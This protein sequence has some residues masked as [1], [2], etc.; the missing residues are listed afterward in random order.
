MLL[1]DDGCKVQTA[2]CVSHQREEET[3]PAIWTVQG[4]RLTHLPD[5]VEGFEPSG[6]ISVKCEGFYMPVPFWH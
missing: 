2:F 1:D 4:V 3:K 6:R 5:L